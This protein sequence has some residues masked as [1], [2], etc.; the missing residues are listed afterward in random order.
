MRT[1][2]PAPCPV[3]PGRVSA[4]RAWVRTGRDGKRRAA[5][6]RPAMA[7]TVKDVMTRDPREVSV[8]TSIVEVAQLM[9]DEDIGSVIVTDGGRLRGLVTDRDVVVRA[10][11]ENLDPS[12]ETV[13]TVYSGRDLVTVD[14]DT[15]IDEA[16]AIM[17]VKAVRR[18]PVV[19]SRGN[20]VGVV[21]IGDLAMERDEDSVLARISAAP[22][23]T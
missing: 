16:A 7:A 11:A 10:V 8:D 2:Y 21:S 12:V 1:P 4:P 20:A 23:N 15:P 5:T 17:R 3:N 18:L 14:P 22:A 9:R 6:R 13:D 19:D